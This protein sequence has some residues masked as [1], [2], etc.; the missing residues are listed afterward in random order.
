[1]GTD[2]QK[3]ENIFDTFYVL[4]NIIYF[5]QLLF[6]INNISFLF[7]ISNCVYVFDTEQSTGDTHLAD[8]NGFC[9]S[10]QFAAHY[11]V[12]ND[13]YIEIHGRIHK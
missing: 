3:D 2:S 9:V 4:Q 10:T 5:I 6:L 11:I 8:N 12:S 1:M 7:L 13:T